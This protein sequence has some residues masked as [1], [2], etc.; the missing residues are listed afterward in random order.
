ME[1]RTGHGRPAAAERRGA[2]VN[3]ERRTACRPPDPRAHTGQRI[4]ARR[5]N[6]ERANSSGAT[7]ERAAGAR[8]HSR[9]SGR[10]T[11][12]ASG[13]CGAGGA[14]GA[15]DRAC[16]MW[17]ACGGRR[18]ARRG[19]GLRIA[20]SATPRRRARGCVR[21]VDPAGRGG[22]TSAGYVRRSR[23]P[24]PCGAA[25][26]SCHPPPTAPVRAP[27]ALVTPRPCKRPRT[28]GPLGKPARRDSALR[29]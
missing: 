12:V 23:A 8:G 10:P 22:V 24:G 19:G 6:D 17:A 13:W 16:H 9:S 21:A 29:M 25:Q 18:C 1:G 3:A 26:R 28:P 15:R 4:G 5:V 11:P 2:C 7:S 20:R 27:R 14:P